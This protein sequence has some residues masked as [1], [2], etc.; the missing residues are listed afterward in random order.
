MWKGSII[1]TGNYNHNYVSVLYV[2]YAC[3]E[4][5]KPLPLKHT[6]S[7]FTLWKNTYMIKLLTI[8][9][10]ACTALLL[11]D[12]NKS[13]TPLPPTTDLK[14]YTKKTIQYSFIDGIDPNLLSLDVYYFGTVT[15]RAPVIVYVHGGGFSIGD[16][17]NNMTNKQNLFSS[18]GYI[19]ISVNYRLS[20]SEYTNDPKRIMY[21][22]HNNDIADAIQWVYNNISD[23]GGDR[24]KIALLGHSAGAHLVALTGISDRFLPMRGLERTLI[25]G[26]ACIDTEGYDVEAR[27]LENN[28]VYRNAFGE[29]NIFWREASPIHGIVKG[30]KYPS[31]FIA[32]RGNSRRI[33]FADAFI[34][35][36]RSADVNVQEITA[37]QYDHEGINDAI[38]AQGEITVTKP[39]QD[40]FVTLFR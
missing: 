14:T 29:T 34:T 40:F 7:H 21:P 31:F 10:F 12:C 15:S 39:L 36:L 4:R 27:C 3:K 6:L 30:K 24:Q 28:E 1:S 16:K 32:K 23:Y 38:G 13:D 26:I 11:T 20:P 22:I 5:T 9:L 17:A 8:I 35:T 37:N 2:E 18:L 19:L 33:G 25:K